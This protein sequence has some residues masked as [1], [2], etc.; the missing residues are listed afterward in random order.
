M[1]IHIIS[2]FPKV[3]EEYIN[4]SVIGRANKEGKVSFKFH[5]PMDFTEPKRLDDKPYGGGPGMVLRALP[6]L[7][8]Y[9]SAKGDK[10]VKTIFFTPGGEKLNREKIVEYKKCDEIILISGRY[11]GIDERV[12]EATGADRISI[13]DYV[14]S[15]G[16]IP[17]M[18]LL[19]VLSREVDGVLGNKESLEDSRVSAHK[20]YT[21]PEV[22]E[23]KGKEYMVPEILL[24][25]HHKEIE[26]FRKDS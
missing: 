16:E 2:L 13:G 15:G 10:E 17:A 6:F 5:N 25:G 12:A 1:V 8:A 21:R 3:F 11:E 14:L 26:D 20:V 23:W 22:F 7:S 24:G 9:E 4:T 19:D 18:V